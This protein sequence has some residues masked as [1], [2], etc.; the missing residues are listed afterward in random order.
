MT[1]NLPVTLTAGT[2][3]NIN[4]V[5]SNFNQVVT[6]MTAIATKAGVS[7][8]TVVRRG[9]SNIV[10]TESTSATSYAIGNL[11]TPDRVQNIV[12]PTD[13]LIAVAYHA[14]WQNTVTVNGRAAIFVGANQ[15]KID[16]S[17]GAGGAPAV[18]EATGNTT[19]N[20][21]TS[22]ATWGQGIAGTGATS[23]ATEVTTGQAVAV[24]INSSPGGPVYIFASAGTYDVSVQFKNTAAGTLTVKNRRL[25]VWTLGF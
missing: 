25:W 10:T 20:V 12:L 21:D 9:K 3:E 6:D 17:S 18:Q 15:L 16:S 13:G 7:D 8:D 11:A 5:T 4:D 23:N 14:L 1:Y 19:V 2:P 24:G 22:L